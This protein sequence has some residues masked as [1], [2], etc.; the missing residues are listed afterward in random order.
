M[1]SQHMYGS[2]RYVQI[3]LV[4]RWF[5]LSRLASLVTGGCQQRWWKVSEQLKVYLWFQNWFF[6]EN[7]LHGWIAFMEVMF[8]PGQVPRLNDNLER[9]FPKINSAH[10]FFCWINRIA[11][12][13]NFRCIIKHDWPMERN[14]VVANIFSPNECTNWKRFF[15]FPSIDYCCG[16]FFFTACQYSAKS[17]K[18]MHNLFAVI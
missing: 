8:S 16:S 13:A 6:L 11:S 7:Y 12:C 5:S 17:A 15:Y 10:I 9:L 4:G 18:E 3:R 1:L 14:V 2:H